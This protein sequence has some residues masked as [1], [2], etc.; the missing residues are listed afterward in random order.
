MRVAVLIG[1]LALTTMSAVAWQS[2]QASWIPPKP[3]VFTKCGKV[4]TVHVMS[5]R[6]Y[7]VYT[8]LKAKHIAE[9]VPVNL[10][11]NGGCTS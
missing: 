5:Q 9:T 4:E 8:G 1:A 10:W 6:G 11:I 7:K 2:A 3:T